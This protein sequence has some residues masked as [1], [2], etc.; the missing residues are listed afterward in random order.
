MT[1]VGVI[2]LGRMGTPIASNLVAAGFEVAVWN[3][4]SAKTESLAESAGVTVFGNPRE[5]AEASDVVISMLS[6]DEASSE[7]HRGLDGVFAAD[8]SP[9][10]G[11]SWAPIARVTSENW[12]PTRPPQS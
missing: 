3:R 7:V 11:W 2:G 5:L 8:P 1:R 9:Q 12:R 6:N 10:Y 4:S